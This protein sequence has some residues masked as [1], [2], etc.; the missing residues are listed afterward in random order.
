[1]AELPQA[2]VVETND[3]NIVRIYSVSGILLAVLEHN[4]PTGGGEATW[5]LRSRN[6][7]LVAT[8]VY[9]YHVETAAGQEKVG[10]FTVVMGIP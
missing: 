6:G 1:M 9:I 10:R 8:G 5:D 3:V 2:G 4:D 7:H